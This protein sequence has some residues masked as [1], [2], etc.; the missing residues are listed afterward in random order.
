MEK[1]SESEMQLGKLGQGLL[2]LALSAVSFG[3]YRMMDGNADLQE[4]YATL[5]SALAV[6]SADCLM[7]YFRK[8]KDN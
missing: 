5:A 3:G 6:F 8:R 2:F 4:V 7:T 1:Q